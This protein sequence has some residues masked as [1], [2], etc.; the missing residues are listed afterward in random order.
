MKDSKLFNLNSISELN[1]NLHLPISEFGNSLQFAYLGEIKKYIEENI[2]KGLF[3]GSLAEYNEKYAAGKISV[4][5]LVVIL[6]EDELTNS[7]STAVLGKAIL[8]SL[9]LGK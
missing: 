1:D 6:S 4:G 7:S 2:D 8:G 5:S 9:L 3:V